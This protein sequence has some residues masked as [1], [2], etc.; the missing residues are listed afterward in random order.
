MILLLSTNTLESEKLSY[1]RILL[2]KN[3]DEI[4]KN[5]NFRIPN[6]EEN[7]TALDA[8]YK[9]QG[10]SEDKQEIISL[11]ESHGFPKYEDIVQN[12]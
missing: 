9:L 3:I 7:L 6:T 2:T 11:L 4:C 12:N 1:L 10:N 8:A 5:S